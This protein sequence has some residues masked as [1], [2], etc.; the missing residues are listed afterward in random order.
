MRKLIVLVLV[1]TLIWAALL[2]GQALYDWE[3]SR[4]MWMTTAFV[5]VEV[6]LIGV[7]VL[8]RLKQIIERLDREVEPDPVRV[9]LV[10]SRPIERDHFEWLREEMGRTNV[11]VTMIVGGGVILSGV[12][13]V[14]DQVAQRTVTPGLEGRLARD[15]HSIAPPADGLVPPEGVLIAEDLSAGE[16]DDLWL[17]LTG[18][19]G[20]QVP[21]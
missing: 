19:H 21:S 7:M 12:L 16:R 20:P 14:I 15:L 11:F 10:E 3:W 1:L 18:R 9:R 13:W 8:G 4:A 6:A 2:A 5:A 17:L